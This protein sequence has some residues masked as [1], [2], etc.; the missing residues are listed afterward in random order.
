MIIKALYYEGPTFTTLD[1]VH[2]GL[3]ITMATVN[4][5]Y[6]SSKMVEQAKP[7]QRSQTVSFPAILISSHVA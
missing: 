4:R 7:V 5:R 2:T 1:T 6:V 3:P